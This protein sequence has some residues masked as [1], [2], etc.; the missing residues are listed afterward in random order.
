MASEVVLGS[1]YMAKWQ[2]A[3]GHVWETKVTARAVNGTGCAVCGGSRILPGFNDLATLEP[4]SA[5]MWH[6]DNE[7]LASEVARRSDYSALWQCSSGHVWRARI[8]DIVDG[9]GCPDC[10]SKTFVSRFEQEIADYVASLGVETETTVRRF[11]GISELDIFAPSL[12][13]AVECHGVYWHSERF[14]PKGVHAAKREACEALGIRLIQ[15]WEDDWAGRRPIVE[16]ML[17][18]KLGAS[19]EP[20]VAAR[21]TTARS[22]TTAEAREFLEANHIQGFTGATYHMG[23]EHDGHLVAV[24]SLKRTGKPGELRLERYAT[25]AHVLGGQSKL[26]RHVEKADPSW[27]HLI[28]F[29]DHEVSD[30]SLYERTGWV[31]DGEL[32]PDYKYRVGNR[33]EHKFSYRLARFRADPALKFEESLSERQLAAVNGLDRIWDSGKTR[34]VLTRFARG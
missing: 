27:T 5:L 24:M 19:A 32:A 1:G 8:A 16:R 33:R 7:K 9:H 18:H 2:C 13:I 11:A 22:V 25:A 4:Q 30:G 29:A 12:N 34:Y 28:T 3:L 26:I 6:E 10:A 20:R 21:S 14:K 15:V 31:K 17:A 23:L